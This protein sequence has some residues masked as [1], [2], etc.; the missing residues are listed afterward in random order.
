MSQSQLEI[1]GFK[2]VMLTTGVAHVLLA[3]SM[4][5]SGVSVMRDFAVPEAVVSA[6]AFEDFFSFFYQ[7]MAYLGVLTILFGHVTRGRTSQVLVASAFCAGNVLL[8]LRD[9]ATSDSI[10]GNQLYR[11]SGTLIPVYIDAI[12][13]VACAAVAIGGLRPPRAPQPAS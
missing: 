9:L 12:F 10:F 2:A 7:L 8:T 3:S 1:R 13:A 4:L 5:V 11:G 6:P